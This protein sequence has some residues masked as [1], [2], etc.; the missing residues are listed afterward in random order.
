MCT[1]FTYKFT[2]IS[3]LLIA[4]ET[5]DVC[6]LQPPT[7]LVPAELCLSVNETM[8]IVEYGAAGWASLIGSWRIFFAY[9]A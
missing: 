2:C 5:E 1:L 6:G 7:G 3:V 9:Y 4:G 8:A